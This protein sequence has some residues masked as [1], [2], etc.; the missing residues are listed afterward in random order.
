MENDEKQ[1]HFPQHFNQLNVEKLLAFYFILETN[2]ILFILN[3]VEMEKLDEGIFF[4]AVLEVV[5]LFLCAFNNLIF[6]NGFFLV[7]TSRNFKIEFNC[8][9]MNILISSLRSSLLIT[10]M[11]KEIWAN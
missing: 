5:W 8:G 11:N 4:L 7:D 10:I 6:P 9:P 3:S 2:E 1:V